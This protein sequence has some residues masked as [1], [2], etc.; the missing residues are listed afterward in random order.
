VYKPDDMIEV[1]WM[2]GGKMFAQWTGFAQSEHLDRYIVWEPVKIV[3][4]DFAERSQ[5]TGEHVWYDCQAGEVTL[6]GLLFKGQV[7]IVT[8]EA[9]PIE[10]GHFGHPRVPCMPSIFEEA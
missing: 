4:D 8:R 1:T 9:L 6:A 3:V 7:R 5:V 2:N 10:R